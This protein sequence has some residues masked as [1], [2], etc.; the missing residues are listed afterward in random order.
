MSTIPTTQSF[1]H[2]IHNRLPS[3]QSSR[4]SPN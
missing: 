4:I 1:K 3:S 2:R